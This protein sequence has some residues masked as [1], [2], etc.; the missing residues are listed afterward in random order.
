MIRIVYF[1]RTNKTQGEVKVRLRLTDGRRADIFHRA[2]I[3][4]SLEDLSKF[5]ADCKL[6]PKIKVYNR[7]LLE[8]LQKESALVE[9]AYNEMVE[10][11]LDLN[12]EVMDSL[13]EGYKT[14]IVKVRKDANTLTACFRDYIDAARRDGVIG[15]RRSA[16]I[17]VVADK[18]ERFLTIKG[19]SQLT[20]KEFNDQQ[21]LDFRQ[22]LYDEY[23]YVP[24]HK[25]LYSSMKSHNVP[26]ERLSTN[27]VVSQLKMLQTFLGEM[28]F[29]GKLDRNPF[30]QLSRERKKAVMKT[31]YDDP[32]YLRS[33]EFST[34]LKAKIPVVLQPV[35]DAFLVQCAFGCRIADFQALTMDNIA[36]S[37][38]GIPF[39]HYLPQKTANAESGNTE[40][41][42]PIARFAFDIIQRTGFN[43][44]IVRN[45]Y[46][47]SGYN[48]LIK[49]LLR[50]CKIDRKVPIYNEARRTNEY[51]PICE[52]GSSKLARKTHV[53]MLS[54]VQIN[55]YA[56]GLHKQG[57]SAVNRY[58]SLEVKDRF[59]LINMAFNQKPYKVNSKLEVV[60]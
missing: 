3:K 17:S 18:L 28:E 47:K 27:T 43:F 46:G 36:I 52:L 26:T 13:I 1:V 48:V 39:I 57:S 4:A 49:S 51:L 40:I 24:K 59:M 5:T 19:L 15:E 41:Q 42:T 23:L 29:Q 58:T 31:K 55:L 35:R 34:L 6:K 9:K 20:P 60:K 33:D 53:D 38:E 8:A 56:A 2:D 44:P 32:V 30:R 10:K 12:A 50:E 16:H 22:F 7:D 54:K 11:G 14:P 21:L 37:E 45:I 25:S